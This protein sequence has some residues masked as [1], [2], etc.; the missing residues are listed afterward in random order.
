MFRNSLKK[1]LRNGEKVLGVFVTSV[2]AA[3]TELAA[4]AG[5]DFVVIDT[6][7]GPLQP[8]HVL[9]HVRAAEARNI[10]AVCRSTNTEA[11]TILRVLDVGSHGIQAPQVNSEEMAQQVVAAATYYP[12]GK[13]GMA[14]PRALDFGMNDLMTAFQQSNEAM[15]VAVHCETK[16]SLDQIEEIAATPGIDVIFLGPFDLSQSLGIPGQVNHALISGAADRILAACKRYGKAAGIFAGDG[17]Q[18]R[19]R[20]QQGFQYVTINMDL[21]LLGMKYREELQKALHDEKGSIS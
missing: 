15:L 13:R 11:T 19:R 5:F 6:E 21:T 4:L 1:R 2:D 14:I 3:V 18:A 16:E 12:M 9:D 17:T 7:H 10:A 8:M 20:M